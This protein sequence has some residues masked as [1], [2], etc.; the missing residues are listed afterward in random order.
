MDDEPV[1]VEFTGRCFNIDIQEDVLGVC[2]SILYWN[3]HYLIYGTC[4]R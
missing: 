3:V 2:Y 4:T 1:I